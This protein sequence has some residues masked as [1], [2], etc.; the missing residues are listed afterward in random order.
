MA[1]EGEAF[2]VGLGFRG[3]GFRVL[4]LYGGLQE[5]K[6]L[7]AVTSVCCVSGCERGHTCGDFGK[8]GPLVNEDPT[9]Q[10]LGSPKTLN[11]KP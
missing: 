5:D 4:R 1:E 11:P 2:L 6:G 9:L 10:T 3:L 8:E 7:I